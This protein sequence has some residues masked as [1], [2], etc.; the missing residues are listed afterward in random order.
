[1]VAVLITAPAFVLTCERFEGKAPIDNKPSQFLHLPSLPHNYI[2]R[3]APDDFPCVR[4]EIFGLE[5]SKSVRQFYN[6]GL[7]VIDMEAQLICYL[8]LCK[9]F[10][11]LM[12]P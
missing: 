5:K 9:A 11:L 12:G 8:T 2:A 6:L 3:Y 10:I 4:Q 7:L 1:M